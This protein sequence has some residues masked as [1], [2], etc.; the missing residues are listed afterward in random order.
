M[1]VDLVRNDI[2]RVAVPG[3]V[4]V[5]AFQQVEAY[6]HV[7]HLVSRV[8]GRLRAGVHVDDL[9]RSLFPGGTITGAPKLRS[10][11]VIDSLEN[12]ARGP[13][14][15]SL[16]YVNPDGTMDLNILIRTLIFS[17]GTAHAYA[18]AGIVDGSVPEKEF[19]ETIHKAA[20]MLIAL[21][22]TRSPLDRDAARPNE[23]ASREDE[24]S[25][26]MH[27]ARRGHPW[28]VAEGGA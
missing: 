5:R 3:S 18:G 2:G 28:P 26:W 1:L 20:A 12:V 17:A 6:S 23:P 10:M 16:G 8:E 14:T 15:G 11:E 22:A 4:R 24:E 9:V 25:Q 27:V 19:E 21:S 7:H 13:Y